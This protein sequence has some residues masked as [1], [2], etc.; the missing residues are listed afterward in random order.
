ML[1]LDLN[2]ARSSFVLASTPHYLLRRIRNDPAVDVLCTHLD[3]EAL[4][5]EISEAISAR[6]EDLDHGVYVYLLLMALA[7]ESDPEYLRRLL[8]LAPDPSYHWFGYLARK[9][10]AEKE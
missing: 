6:P 1:D 7:R 2:E 9:L 8:R 3:G 4:Y 5:K 10:L